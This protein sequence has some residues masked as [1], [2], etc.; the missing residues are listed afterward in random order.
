MLSHRLQLG[1]IAPSSK[2]ASEIRREQKDAPHRR[3]SGMS[4]PLFSLRPAESED[5]RTAGDRAPE[6]GRDPNWQARLDRA[7]DVVDEGLPSLSVALEMGKGD[8]RLAEDRSV[9]LHHQHDRQ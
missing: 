1:L 4:D 5:E 3:G 9:A 2:E 7:V 6:R 8:A